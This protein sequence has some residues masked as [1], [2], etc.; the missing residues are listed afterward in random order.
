M[1]SIEDPTPPPRLIARTNLHESTNTPSLVY[2]NDEREQQQTRSYMEDV[3]PPISSFTNSVAIYQNKLQATNL[4]DRAQTTQANCKVNILRSE[5][6]RLREEMLLKINAL[7]SEM[8][9]HV[10]AFESRE[11][12]SISTNSQCEHRSTQ[13]ENIHKVSSDAFPLERNLLLKI[14][15]K[16]CCLREEIFEKLDTFFDLEPE[17]R[18]GK[19][20][21][22]N[23]AVSF[24]EKQNSPSPSPWSAGSDKTSGFSMVEQSINSR[25]PPIIE[26]RDSSYSN[27]ASSRSN[28][29]CLRSYES[30]NRKSP[31]PHH[32]SIPSSSIPRTEQIRMVPPL[33]TTSSKSS[34]YQPFQETFTNTDQYSQTAREELARHLVDQM[35]QYDDLADANVRG[36]KGKRLLN[37]MK[38]LKIRETIFR[39][40]PVRISENEEYLWKFICDKINAKCRGVTRTLKRKSNAW[41]TNGEEM[42]S[43][44]FGSNSKYH[45]ETYQ[46]ERCSFVPTTQSSMERRQFRV[47]SSSDSDSSIDNVKKYRAEGKQQEQNFRQPN[48]SCFS[49]SIKFE[50]ADSISSSKTNEHEDIDVETNRH[51]EEERES[52]DGEQSSCDFEENNRASPLVLQETGSSSSVLE[53][54]DKLAEKYMENFSQQEENQDRKRTQSNREEFTRTLIEAMFTRS[55]LAQSNVTGARGKFMLDPIKIVK[56]RETVFRKFPAANEDEEEMLWKILTTK[57]NTK[58]RGVKRLM[59]RKGISAECVPPYQYQDIPDTETQQKPIFSS[60]AECIPNRYEEVLDVEAKQTQLF[61]NKVHS[62][63]FSP[64]SVVYEQ[65]SSRSSSSQ[66]TVSSS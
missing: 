4:D 17:Q 10:P 60:E 9:N 28:I 27:N 47:P 41:D 64:A 13:T 6:S 66:Y 19:R 35:F 53:I 46:L 29:E 54:C 49:S 15:E 39:T 1:A 11:T 50:N 12:V 52:N 34:Y 55:T 38:I 62:T 20:N 31:V 58:C 18:I 44:H 48:L 26:S 8:T 43:Q 21:L 61:N 32:F 33:D 59:K 30:Y 57:I 23:S 2:V 51:E 16:L 36:V 7:E 45:K 65:G 14:D 5:I 42:A 63:F 3:S 56:V 25:S 37:P 22:R 40:Y 24:Q